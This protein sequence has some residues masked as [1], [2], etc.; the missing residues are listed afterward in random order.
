MDVTRFLMPL[1]KQHLPGK[2]LYGRDHM[3]ED[4]INL[5]LYSNFWPSESFIQ[6]IKQNKHI[7]KIQIN[8]TDINLNLTNI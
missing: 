3:L 7:N 2:S 5:N 4:W 6:L 1:I 8:K